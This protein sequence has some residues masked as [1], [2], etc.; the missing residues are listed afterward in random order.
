MKPFVLRFL[1]LLLAASLFGGASV[2]SAAEPAAPRPRVIVSTDIGGTDFDDFQSLVHLLLYSDQIDLEGMIASPWGPTRN[3]KHHLLDLIDIYAR[4]YPNLRT[5]S[6][7][8]PTPDALRALSKQGGLDSADLRGFGERTEGSD[9]IIACAKRPDPR[10]LWVLIWGGIDDLAQALHDDPSIKAKLHVYCIGGP[11]KKW[12]TTAYDYIAREHPDL[13]IIENNSTY[14]GWFT[15]GDQSGDLENTAFVSTQ[16]KGRGALGDYFTTI[17]PK[18]KMGDTPSFAYVL[19]A[20][21]ENPAA[22][23]WGGHFVRAWDRPRVT[24]TSPPSSADKV[25]TF[26]IVELIHRPTAPAPPG[27]IVKATLVVDGQEFPG[28]PSADGT[29]H[30]LFCP[31][32]AKTWSYRIASNHPGLDGQTG[33]FTSVNPAPEQ[34]AAPSV[35]YPNW[36]TDDPAPEFAEGPHQGAKTINRWRA[37]FLHDFAARLAHCAAPA[38]VVAPAA[39]VASKSALRWGNGLLKRDAVWYSSA[40]ARAAAEAVIGYQSVHGAWP[41]NTDLLVPATPE[42][43]AAIEKAGKANTI[44]NSA[45]TTPIRFLA[46]VAHAT[47]EAT[48][49]TAVLRGVDYLLASQYANG[50]FPQFY[51]L[52]DHGYYSHITYNDG[53]MIEAL[54]VLRDV[55]QARP[56]YGFLDADIR[57]KAADAVRRGIDCILKTQIKQDGKLTVWCAQHDEKTL[58]PAWARKYEPPSLSG[59]ESVGV[60]HFLMAEKHPSPEI[61]AAIEGGVAWLRSVQ[62]SGER[63]ERFVDEA[64]KKDRRVVEDA[65][66]DPIW[67]RF[68]ELDTNRPLFMDRDSLPTYSLAEIDQERRA[69]YGYLGNWPAALLAKDY[70]AWRAA[71]LAETNAHAPDDATLWHLD[72]LDSIGGHHVTVAGEPKV[73]ATPAGKAIEF[74]G[75]DDALFLDIN[76]LAGLAAFTVEIVFSPYADGAAE[77]RF[78]HIQENESVSRV[79]F[80]T[81]LVENRLWFLDTFIQSGAKK[82][83]NLAQD[84][85]H[86][87]GPWYHA[88]IVVDGKSFKHFVNGRQELEKELAYVV[89]K[90]GRT[91]LGV[92]LNKVNWFK[93]AIRTIR[94]TPR[95]LTPN[96]FLSAED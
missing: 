1:A 50:G 18:I 41:K 7:R 57:A 88:A 72:N 49:R 34:A 25:E 94:V 54:N 62:I 38:P 40:E 35:R 48:Y 68:Y 5:H 14:R 55:A 20:T 70:P 46:L 43:I 85:R 33:G 78:F 37:D 59:C 17:A 36:W 15:G 60:I 23:S 26:A 82:V 81:R 16:I 65:A 58:A 44:D 21:R 19:G 11:N 39:P 73:I 71:H 28:F 64:G 87:I 4:D 47:G 12:S 77:Q 6:D 29:W 10:P 51:P 27:A 80:E 52:R 93:G 56:E 45:T 89:Q 79:L 24:F 86:A 31:K 32:D 95:P 76:P 9:W 75:I 69:G 53:A 30:F 67:A 90:S 96:E 13:W 8:Y 61:V 42:L 3:R 74:D 91:S 63:V 66:A 84:D 83:V 92:R 2:S 22:D